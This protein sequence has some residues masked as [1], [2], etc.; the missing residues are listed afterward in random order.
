M[1][2]LS[3]LFAFECAN[4]DVKIMITRDDLREVFPLSE[5]DFDPLDTIK[6][7]SDQRN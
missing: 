7:V 2:E 5:S 3:H 1:P 4:C 6:A